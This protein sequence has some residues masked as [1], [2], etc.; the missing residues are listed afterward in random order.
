MFN[1]C[2][3]SYARSITEIAMESKS[4]SIYGG[5]G[6]AIPAAIYF[7]VFPRAMAIIS[8]IVALDYVSSCS[9]HQN[10]M[11]QLTK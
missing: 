8:A 6:T 7:A 5:R 9:N 10:L 3:S 11:H 4:I 2:M 1:D